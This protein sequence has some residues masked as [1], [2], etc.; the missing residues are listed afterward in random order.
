[1]ALTMSCQF[2]QGHNLGGLYGW[3][4]HDSCEKIGPSCSRGQ[5]YN[6]NFWI[7]W[8]NFMYV[9]VIFVVSEELSTHTYGC[10]IS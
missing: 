4:A 6:V 9:T 10:M 3:A 5:W 8:C 7:L 2:D 1:M